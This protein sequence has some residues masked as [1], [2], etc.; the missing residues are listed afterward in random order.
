MMDGGVVG[1]NG[2]TDENLVDLCTEEWGQLSQRDL[3]TQGR[4]GGCSW[5]ARWAMWGLISFAF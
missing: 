2:N 4:K 3:C 1:S 5:R